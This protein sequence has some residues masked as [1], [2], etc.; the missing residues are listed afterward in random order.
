MLETL[1]SV[2]NAFGAAILVPVIIIIIAMILKVPLKKALMAGLN[3]G[4]GLQGFTLVINSF[5]PI[6]SPV[7]ES[8]VKNTGINLPA[9]DVGWQATSIVAYS[10]Q[11]G[12]VFLAVGIILQTVLFLV[13]WTDVFQPSDLWNNYSYAIWGSMV[14][15][16]TDNMLLAL[17]C[18]ILLNMYSLLNSE[19][20]ARRWSTYYG[21]P[22]TTIVGMHNIEPAIFGLV[23]DPVLNALGFN[24]IKINPETLQKRLG[25]FGEPIVL[26]F[27]IGAIIGLIGNISSLDTVSAWGSTLTVAIATAAVMAIFPKIAGIFSNAFTPI[28]DAA[29]KS[30]AKREK[31]SGREWF[32]GIN[33]AA[34]FGEPATLTAGLILIPIM[35][36]MAF[37]LPGNKVI[38]VI[39]L[40][41]LPFMVQ[42]LVA[43][44]NG[45]MAKVIVNGI[46]WFS[47]GLYICTE[48]A[49]LFTDIAVDIGISLPAGALLITSFNILSKPLASLVFFAFLSGSPLWISL[50]IIVYLVLWF[51]FRKNKKSFYDYLDRQA[52]KNDPEPANGQ[53]A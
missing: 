23:M 18:M 7:I 3:A 44:T 24:K 21:Y 9:F 29:R 2:F 37:I 49:Q 4:I 8:M 19:V 47:I 1:Q 42:G 50:V 36:L 14:Y 53:V 34:G 6:I 15:I 28:T 35:V 46:I 40:V 52:A 11:P 12:M 43:L 48:T 27:F 32:L 33:D 25:I 38:P 30:T 45:N 10:T 16:V 22:N 13:K 26:G 31:G 17:G 41:A 39:D 5:T 51:L 20:I